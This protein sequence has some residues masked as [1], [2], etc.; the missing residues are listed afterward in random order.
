MARYGNPTLNDG[1]EPISLSRPLGAPIHG[2]SRELNLGAVPSAFGSVADSEAGFAADRKISR[3][4]PLP[5]PN[6]PTENGSVTRL[7]MRCQ[8]SD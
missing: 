7:L 5:E 1:L 3:I 6:E 8:K 4:C 2:P